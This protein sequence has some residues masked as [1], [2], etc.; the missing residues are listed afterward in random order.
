M[1]SAHKIEFDAPRELAQIRLPRSNSTV[2]IDLPKLEIQFLENNFALEIFSRSKDQSDYQLVFSDQVDTEKIIQ[3]L[4]IPMENREKVNEL[5][6]RGQFANLP[7]VIYAKPASDVT[8]EIIDAN[9][10]F[11]AIEN[12]RNNYT[13]L[14]NR[15]DPEL[16]AL[17]LGKLIFRGS[18]LEDIDPSLLFSDRAEDVRDEENMED[19]GR[20]LE[21]QT[22]GLIVFSKNSDLLKE[23]NNIRVYLNTLNDLQLLLRQII[24]TKKSSVHYP[25]FLESSIHKEMVTSNVIEIGLKAIRGDVDHFN[26]IILGVELLGSLADS[27]FKIGISDLQ[28]FSSIGVSIGLQKS[29]LDLYKKALFNGELSNVEVTGTL[30]I[31]KPIDEEDVLRKRDSEARNRSRS[32]KSSRKEKRSRERNE[33][34]EKK[35]KKDKKDK[36][37]K[38]EKKESRH[39]DSEERKDKK[40]RK[41]KASREVDKEKKDRKDKKDKKERKE[42]KDK[43]SKRDRKKSESFD[44]KALA[45]EI[46]ELPNDRIYV[47]TDL[48]NIY[49]YNTKRLLNCTN[50]T[51]FNICYDTQVLLTLKQYIVLLSEDLKSLEAEQFTTPRII[52][53]Y[54]NTN[55]HLRKLFKHLKK[56]TKSQPA[57]EQD[58]NNIV[59]E[60]KSDME[61]V[62]QINTAVYNTTRKN[63]EK[64]AKVISYALANILNESKLLKLLLLVLVN[65]Q[66]SNSYLHED[67]TIL[68]LN[69]MAFFANC[70]G[71]VSFLIKDQGFFEDFLSM[72]KG[73]THINNKP[74]YEESALNTLNIGSNLFYETAV[75]LDI[76]EG[77][78]FSDPDRRQKLV[79][80]Q[81]YYYFHN[82]NLG[83]AIINDIYKSLLVMDTPHDLILSLIRLNRFIDNSLIAQQAFASILK[84]EYIMDTFILILKVDSIELYG[85][86]RLEIS[87]VC[88]II[89]KC[90]IADDGRLVYKH[91]VSL[92][93]AL[94]SV[95]HH[96]DTYFKANPYTVYEKEYMQLERYLFSLRSLLKP[97]KLLS[98]DFQSFINGYQEDSRYT[99]TNIN[100]LL[101]NKQHFLNVE[102]EFPRS[103]KKKLIARYNDYLSFFKT[104]ASKNNKVVPF[105]QNL[106]IFNYTL[107]LNSSLFNQ[108]ISANIFDVLNF[109][110]LVSEL[111]ASTN[112]HFSLQGRHVRKVYTDDNIDILKSHLMLLDE[113]VKIYLKKLDFKED[114]YNLDKEYEN[115]DL[116]VNLIN[117]LTN[118]TKFNPKLF[119]EVCIQEIFELQGAL[120]TNNKE[121]KIGNNKGRVLSKLTAL[122][123]VDKS[124]L[125]HIYIDEK[126]QSHV[127]SLIINLVRLITKWSLY[128]GSYDILLSELIFIIFNKN[129]DRAIAF[130]LLATFINKPKTSINREKFRKI[131]HT[132]LFEK[133]RTLKKSKLVLIQKYGSLRSDSLFDIHVTRNGFGTT[134]EYIIESFVLN[135]DPELFNS[136]SCLLAAIIDWKD[137]QFI[138]QIH[139][140]LDDILLKYIEKLNQT[141]E[142]PDECQ[143]VVKKVAKLVNLFYFLCSTGTFKIYLIESKYQ[144]ILTKLLDVLS[145]PIFVH[146]EVK[147]HALSLE[148]DINNVFAIFMDP[149][150]GFQFQKIEMTI[151]EKNYTEILQPK[152]IVKLIKY[153]KKELRRPN[154]VLERKMQSFETEGN[155]LEQETHLY[156]TKLRALRNIIK[157]P[158]GKLVCLYGEYTTEVFKKTKPTLKLRHMTGL[159]SDFPSLENLKTDQINFVAQVFKVYLSLAYNL[160]LDTDDVN[161]VTSSYRTRAFEKIIG[162]TVQE[163]CDFTGRAIEILTSRP[164]RKNYAQKM[165]LYYAGFQKYTASLSDKSKHAERYPELPDCVDLKTRIQKFNKSYYKFEKGLLD[166]LRDKHYYENAFYSTMKVISNWFLKESKYKNYTKS[167]MIKKPSY[168]SRYKGWFISE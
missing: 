80:S 49:H 99:L 25:Y 109:V 1:S 152:D 65:P 159:F 162:K 58:H 81:Y 16:S 128:P 85:K 156:F 166:H 7:L 68:C 160:L 15:L 97:I 32:K 52:E 13:K 35:E 17:N 132:L 98:E 66:L 87:L 41:D 27:G 2:H 40:H 38:K 95:Q 74:I 100:T 60:L 61:T 89:Y 140:L 141:L 165:I 46:P 45:E 168:L 108:Y 50:S 143:Q 122:I 63:S 91:H 131:I 11:E 39:R 136:I 48:Q 135:A 149:D 37:D 33:K 104:E 22:N 123:F 161:F 144:Y 116:F 138:Q 82:L 8:D 44:Q 54:E 121:T 55:F 150:I 154:N 96:V 30:A 43:K 67:I 69:I 18:G 51:T 9:A 142:D 163:F 75:E 3:D 126:T 130:Y 70:V 115:F 105:Y 133:V 147:E 24:A 110:T 20:K 94:E 78:N 90:L 76:L 120:N 86:V 31:P 148:A 19:I 23:D 129:S 158:V 71:G 102:R 157:N 26:E 164:L 10:R 88:E 101:S 42:K 119:T 117:L 114:K 21:D 77:D 56:L 73:I 103:D 29:C 111:I 62:V 79:L 59:Q 118:L 53:I 145:K 28:T 127:N 139:Q 106:K 93:K 113:G 146:E 47:K 92:G 57:T 155:E 112:L 134:I 84:E 151:E 137:F 5:I 64:Q 125:K 34:K 72:L 12:L 107:G 4:I 6:I 153:Y 83:M 167:N 124:P 36:K 14:K